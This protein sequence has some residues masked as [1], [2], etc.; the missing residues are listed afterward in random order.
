MKSRPPW[1]HE[2]RCVRWPQYKQFVGPFLPTA[3][4]P[5]YMEW[6][7]FA[8]LVVRAVACSLEA[9]RDS[10][11]KGSAAPTSHSPVKND[12]LIPWTG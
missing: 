8:A 3:A 5:A 7:E 11:R 6:M 10:M 2:R 12:G 4:A 1:R 9:L